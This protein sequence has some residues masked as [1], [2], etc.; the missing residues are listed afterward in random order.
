MKIKIMDCV[1]SD[2][3][4]KEMNE[5]DDKEEVIATQRETVELKGVIHWIATCYYKPKP[6]TLKLIQ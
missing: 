3:L 4:Q 1:T 6:K 2:Q 5:F